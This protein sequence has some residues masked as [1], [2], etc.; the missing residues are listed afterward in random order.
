M[1]A[2]EACF[3]PTY[4]ASNTSHEERL[5]AIRDQL[6]EAMI[7]WIED[8]LRDIEDDGRQDAIDEAYMT[9]EDG[10]GGALTRLRERFGEGSGN[11][12][13]PAGI[14][15]AEVPRMIEAVNEEIDKIEDARKAAAETLGQY[16][17]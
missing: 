7:G 8:M 14:T 3:L 2:T 17:E 15:L 5:A 9:I 6:P 10:I 11:L 12:L 1:S 4:F 13:D 16:A